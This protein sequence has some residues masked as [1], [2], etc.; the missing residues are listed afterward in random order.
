VPQRFDILA[1]T[2]EVAHRMWAGDES[3]FHGRQVSLEH[4]I[5]RPLPVSRP[6][7]P[8]LVGGT[9][10]RRTLRLVAEHAD[11]CN[12]FDIPDGGRTVTRKLEV[13][14]SHC[15]A[16]GRPYD[17]VQ[18]TITTALDETESADQFVQR[19]GD[20]GE[21]GI[22]H[23]IVITRGRPWADDDVTTLGAAASQLAGLG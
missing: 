7:P 16:V 5:G 6:R 4:P 21:L 14:R 19:C 17:D 22:Q 20:L 18:R 9:G 10:E 3:A 2:L 15:L 1:D 11:A 12:L 23:V 8:I 13:L